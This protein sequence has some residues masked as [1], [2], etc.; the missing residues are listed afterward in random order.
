L[1]ENEQHLDPQNR[2]CIQDLRT[3]GPRE[4]KKRI[5]DTKGGLLEGS[6]RW[7]LEHSDFQEWRDN[8]QSRLL[9]IKGDPG[10]GKTIDGITDEA[11]LISLVS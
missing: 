5:E 4:D 7:I 9:W 10:K 2:S 1:Q 6:Y 8:K 11:P 3:T